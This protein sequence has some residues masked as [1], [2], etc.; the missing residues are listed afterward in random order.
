MVLGQCSQLKSSAIFWEEENFVLWHK[1]K[2]CHCLEK[3][4]PSVQ[5]QTSHI[6]AMLATSW[7]LRKYGDGTVGRMLEIKE[8]K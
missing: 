8:G 4:Y 7:T 5:S 1:N 2:N 6:S 3:T